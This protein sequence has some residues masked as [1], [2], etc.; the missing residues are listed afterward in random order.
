MGVVSSTYTWYME[1]GVLSDDDE[2][3]SVKDI[4]YNNG[5]GLK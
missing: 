4:N 5:H 3:E 1:G 2:E